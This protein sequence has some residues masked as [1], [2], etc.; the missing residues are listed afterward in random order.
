MCSEFVVFLTIVKVCLQGC[1]NGDSCFFS[2]DLDPA[3]SEFSGSG[4]CLPEDGDADAVL[5]LQFFP[6]ALGGRVLVLDD[7]DLHFTI[8]LAHKFNPFKIISTTCLPNISICDPS[9]TAVKILWGLREPYKAIISTEGENPIPW[10]EVECIL[11]F[12]N[13]ESYG[14]NLEGQKN[15]IQKFFECLAVRIL[16]DAMYQVQVIL[17][18]KNI[19]FSQLQVFTVDIKKFHTMLVTA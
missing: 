16:A 17:T 9:L 14:G 12:P 8:N 13:F 7:T 15:L 2:H 11:W 4:E 18:M 5:L 3:V 10:N 19:R 6:N 1:R